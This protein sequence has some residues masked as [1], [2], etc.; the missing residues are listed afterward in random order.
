MDKIPKDRMVKTHYDL[1]PEVLAET[2]RI[3]IRIRQF[4]HEYGLIPNTFCNF[5][6]RTY[7]DDEE[8]VH[9]V[10][11]YV[12]LDNQSVRDML[13]LPTVEPVYVNNG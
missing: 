4:L 13:S 6:S 3:K 8:F 11:D 2:T 10:L 5:F 1:T 7:L 12:L 9:S